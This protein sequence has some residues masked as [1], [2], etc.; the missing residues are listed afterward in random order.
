M[1]TITRFSTLTATS[2]I[3]LS[4][5]TAAMA[6]EADSAATAAASASASADAAATAAAAAVQPATE[7]QEPIVVTGLRGKPRTATD[8]PVPV[9]V[10]GEEQIQ[11]TAATDTLEVLQT[12]SPSYTVSRSPNTD[13]DSFVRAPSLR[14]LPANKTLML[15][16]GRRRH[17]SGSVGIY[18][19]ASQAADAATIPAIALQNVEV[20]RDGAAAQYG[21]DAIAGVIN[22]QLK[23]A[24]SGGSLIAQAGQYYEGD[25]ESVM[26]AGNI[27][28]PLTDAGFVN[29]SA[30][31]NDD[32]NTV[33]SRTF[34]SSSWDPFEAYATD[35]A[36]A[37]AVDAAG[38]DLN[39]PLEIRGKP[40]ERAA[41]FVINSGIDITDNSSLYAFANYSRS[42]G[43]AYGSYRTPGGGHNV[44]DNPIR[45]DDGSV[46]T[47]KEKYPLGLQPPFMGDVTDW[48]ATGGYRT[49]REFSN[50]HVLSA[51]LS[52]R[53]GYNKIQYSMNGTV[54][55]SYGPYSQENFKAS[56]YTSDEFALNG[57]FVYQMPV[58]FYGDLVF[59]FGTEF[60]RE[61]YRISPG[62]LASYSGGIWSEQDPFNFCSNEADLASRT[63]NAGAPTDQGID[64]TSSSD[65]VYNILQPGSNGITGLSPDVAGRWTTESTSLYGEISSEVT[66]K[67]F[68]DFA[69][70][71]EDYSSFGDKLVWKAA[72]RYYVTDWAAIRGS[73]GTG[74][75][76]PSTGQLYITQTTISTRD[77]GTINLGLYP[78]THPVAEYLGATP[79]RPETSDNYSLGFTLTP[80]PNL[81]LTVDAYRIK[82]YDRVY[83]SSTIMVTDEI[84]DAMFAAGVNDAYSIDGIRFFQNAFDTTT[85]GIDVVGTYKA[86]WLE[87]G[88]TSITAAFNINDYK[89]D[90][91]NVDSITFS[92]VSVYNFEHN[93]PKWRAN[94]TLNQDVGAISFMLRGNFYGPNSRQ[95][96][97]SGN[98]IQK[99]K[100]QAMVDF[101][102]SAPIGDGFTLAVGGQNIFDHYPEIN[103]IDDR[104]G[105]TYVDGPV[106]WQGGYYYGRIT[107]DF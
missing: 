89:I 3:A 59:N 19:D 100:T 81:T 97:S 8:S 102:V 33:R 92:D 101:Q 72:A 98:A 41:R 53:Y 5:S 1:N 23:D 95:T 39:D 34:S 27:G 63:L 28:L 56:A 31:L 54:N 73:I 40:K 14:G 20:L 70:R 30:Q 16:N 61:G 9:D 26:I 25:G 4:I 96:T 46:W 17:K 36:F 84:Q 7:T 78:A 86:D 104:N 11:N 64:C 99:W 44:L 18:R 42:Q 45:L 87:A 79:L 13:T 52:A 35:A 93:N 21:S 91:L 90:R 75:R 68:L 37:A 62:E 38:I 58:G 105:R 76:A 22:F 83:A 48:S 2:A 88:S 32:Q 80:T 51:D 15:V 107:F 103:L 77:G 12:L 71:Y 85:Q 67:L 49:E 6:N 82:M 65:P 106:S 43:T 29:I 10:F 57:D 94:M 69:A 47:F 50:G 60:R 74:F 55:P 24:S 66:E